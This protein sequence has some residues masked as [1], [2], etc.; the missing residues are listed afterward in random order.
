[1]LLFVTALF[2]NPASASAQDEP[3]VRAVTATAISFGSEVVGLSG[4]FVLGTI[5]AIATSP[6]GMGGVA[7]MGAGGALGLVGGT[8]SSGAI[9]GVATRRSPLAMTGVTAGVSLLGMGTMVA[10]GA[11]GGNDALF[12][13]L[14]TLVAVPVA[15]GVAAAVLPE[16]QGRR[17][18]TSV[19]V[20]PTFGR[21]GGGLRI[22]GNF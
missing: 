14:G 6:E 7:V 11:D 13:G 3:A 19:S 21:Q 10:V 12:V 9:A 1:M 22:A 2:A 4:G 18:R 8:M 16:H 20:S 17:A 5:A 15:A